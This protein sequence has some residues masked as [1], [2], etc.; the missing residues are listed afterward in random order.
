MLS[1]LNFT[2]QPYEE[3]HHVNLLVSAGNRSTQTQFEI[4]A[5]ASDLNDV[6]ESLIGFPKTDNDSLMWEL[7][8]ENE[9][10]RFAFYFHVRVFQFSPTGRCAI[11]IRFNNNQEPPNQ[12]ITEFCIEAYPSDLDRLGTMFESFGRLEHLTMEWSVHP[13][14]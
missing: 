11:E 13:G 2:R 8:S 7:G 1:F 4:Y 14:T 9:Q 10:D 12:Q 3:P 6:A 5:N